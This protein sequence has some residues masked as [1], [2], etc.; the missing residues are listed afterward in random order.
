MKGDDTRNLASI[1]VQANMLDQSSGHGFTCFIYYFQTIQKFLSQFIYIFTC[2]LSH[3]AIF[4]GSNYGYPP[5]F[6]N[7]SNPRRIRFWTSIGHYFEVSSMLLFAVSLRP[8]VE[9]IQLNWIV[10]ELRTYMQ[11]PTNSW[12]HEFKP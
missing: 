3:R 6:E 5:I 1:L 9:K 10:K 12:I 2:F 7:P 4:I 11:N 8:P